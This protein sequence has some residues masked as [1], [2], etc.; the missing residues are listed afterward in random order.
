[1]SG[2]GRGPQTILNVA[3]NLLRGTFER[4]VKNSG[5]PISQSKLVATISPNM[6]NK[7]KKA[8]KKNKREAF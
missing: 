7:T 1:M 3:L 8:D 4:I 2:I 6:I 5:T